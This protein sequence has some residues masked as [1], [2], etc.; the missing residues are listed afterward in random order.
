MLILTG[1]TAL[2]L[3]RL[4]RGGL[5]SESEALALG[6][7]LAGHSLLLTTGARLIYLP[8]AFLIT[9][10]PATFSSLLALTIPAGYIAVTVSACFGSNG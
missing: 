5:E 2:V 10:R 6:S 7:F 3:W 8:V 4:F 1:L 9:G